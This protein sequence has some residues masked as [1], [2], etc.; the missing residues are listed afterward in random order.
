MKFL[1]VSDNV[2]FRKL[3]GRNLLFI[4]EDGEITESGKSINPLSQLDFTHFHVIF[5]DA[6]NQLINNIDWLQTYTHNLQY[7][8]VIFITD[9]KSDAYAK[10]LLKA[11]AKAVLAKTEL[12][13]KK[14]LNAVNKVLVTPETTIEYEGDV[15]AGEDSKPAIPGYQVHEKSNDQPLSWIVSKRD[16]KSSCEA[17]MFRQFTKPEQAQE[18]EQQIVKLKNFQHSN[19]IH[20]LDA[21]L[22][23]SDIGKVFL[24]QKKHEIGLRPILPGDL[25]PKQVISS[26]LAVLSGLDQLHKADF[27]CGFLHP[28]FFFLDNDNT[29]I[30]SLSAM[31]ASKNKRK[32]KYASPERR[33]GEKV[34]KRS[35]YYSLAA[36][37]HYFIS[38]REPEA[39]ETVGYN[40]DYKLLERVIEGA[41][42]GIKEKRYATMPEFE[43][44]INIKCTE[45]LE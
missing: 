13:K 30:L 28:D 3:F 1:I 5:I 31:L 16:I 6:R 39:G 11:G 7:P 10:D 21:G 12:T 23:P 40:A 45:L 17:F 41:L 43:R 44:F 2:T 36:V 29:L 15:Y 22:L 4:W 8:P 18:I 34:D 9:D 32:S 24:V 19:F 27:V 33:R 38:G 26:I 35:D 42:L 37:F 20:I 14:I 25:S